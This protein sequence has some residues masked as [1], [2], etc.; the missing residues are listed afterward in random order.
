MSGIDLDSIDRALSS[1]RPGALL[2][3]NFPSNPIGYSP[4]F[5]EARA[6]VERVA[7]H[8]HPLVVLTDD[9]Y[10]GMVWEPGLLGG[11]LFP[12]LNRET[13][14]HILPIKID[15]AT[16]E[17]FFFGGRVGFLS[18][19]C[20][21]EPGAVLVEKAH[22]CIR[23]TISSG[24]T[25]SQNLVLQALQDPALESQARE[26][27]EQI[28]ERYLRLKAALLDNGIPSWPFNSAFFTLLPV[29][30]DPDALRR[31]LLAQGVGVISIPQASALRLSYASV[32]LEDLD[33]LVRSLRETLAA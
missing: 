12:M 1:A 27:R 30:G 2:V 11:S 18:F 14:E 9:A 26:L 29:Q 6:L 32:A 19:G 15:G 22:A 3:L 16:K 7:A 13:P 28:R 33:A 31:E 8:P 21:A 17:L 24:A 20:D 10:Q 4:T 23:A 5:S 25:L